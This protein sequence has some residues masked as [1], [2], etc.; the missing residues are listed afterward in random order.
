MALDHFPEAA[1]VRESRH[2]L[3]HHLCRTSGQRAVSHV[4]VAGDPANIGR[5]P[6]HVAR[7]QVKRP[8]HGLARPQRI[9]P[10]G[11]LHPLGLARRTAGVEDEKRV[12]SAHGHGSALGALAR[13]GLG[14]GD[15]AAFDAVPGAGRALINQH[16]LHAVAAAHG[17]GFVDDGLERQ[18]LATTQLV[19]GRDDG[20]GTRVDGALM[21]RLGRKA[22]KHHAVRGTDARTRLHGHHALNGHGHVDQY[23]VTLLHA[24]C[25]ER[26]GELAH[27]GKQL[28]VGDLRNGAVV[29]FEDDGGLVLDRRADV[30]IQAVG[31]SV[32]LTI[33]KPLVERRI[34]LVQRLR[35][36]P[37]PLQV[38]A[39]QARPETLEV[40]LGFG[41]QGLVSLHAGNAGVLHRVFGR[42]ENAVFHQDGFDRG[43]GLTHGVV[44]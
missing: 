23:A 19:V 20:H 18:L 32:Q 39:R 3:E 8:Q 1:G 26:V 25:L 36:R 2:A 34:G 22:A 16:G 28:L 38:L 33:G 4:G 43:C 44:S 21:Q 31:R 12:F 10:G 13:Q 11:V 41:A 6:E 40:F 29:S 15:V 30:A 27:T 14:E 5:A 42:R 35:E 24:A 9:A 17:Q 7:L 37:A